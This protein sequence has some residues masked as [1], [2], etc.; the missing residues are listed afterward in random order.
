MKQYQ[1]MVKVKG[2]MTLFV[3]NDIRPRGKPHLSASRGYLY[4]VIVMGNAKTTGRMPIINLNLNA[5][6]GDIY[7]RMPGNLYG[8]R[9]HF[10]NPALKIEVSDPPKM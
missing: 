10:D 8:I 3:Y 5:I 4:F 7:N 2:N 6:F 1:L 9:T